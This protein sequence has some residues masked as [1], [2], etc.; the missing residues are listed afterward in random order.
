M[1]DALALQ[2]N[3]DTEQWLGALLPAIVG[4]MFVGGGIA[5]LCSRR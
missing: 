1:T 3:A 2:Q 5:A 4:L